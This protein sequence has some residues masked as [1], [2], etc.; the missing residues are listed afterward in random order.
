MGWR[1]HLVR[2]WR[3]SC[4]HWRRLQ[5]WGRG[6]GGLRLLALVSEGT[7]HHPAMTNMRGASYKAPCHALSAELGI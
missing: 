6:L 2:G 3:E 7:T 5:L 4:L 1:W